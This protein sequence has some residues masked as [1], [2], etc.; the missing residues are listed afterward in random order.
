MRTEGPP[1]TAGEH[2]GG[3]GTRDDSPAAWMGWAVGRGE[4]WLRRAP[5]FVP[6]DSLLPPLI[7]S[8]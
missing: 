4:P 5:S 1:G 3:L 2:C 7:T 6:S 8:L